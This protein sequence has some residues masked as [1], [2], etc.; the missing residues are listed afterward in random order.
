MCEEEK[1]RLVLLLFLSYVVLELRSG[2]LL[3]KNKSK[4]IIIIINIYNNSL[5]RKEG[6]FKYTKNEEK[7]DGVTKEE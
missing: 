2:F 1:K 4:I 6:A 7:D 5:T 3:V